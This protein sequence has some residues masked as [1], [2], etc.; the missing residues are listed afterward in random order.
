MSA[1]LLAGLFITGAAVIAILVDQHDNSC[2]VF[3]VLGLFCAALMLLSYYIEL[4]TIGLAPKLM[5]VKFGYLGRV[6]VNPMLL[7]LV[8]RY[9]GIKIHKVLQGLIY[10]IPLVT[11]VLVFTCDTNQ[12]YYKQVLL[13]PDG[14]LVVQPGIFYLVYMGYTTVLALIYLMLCLSQ[15]VT[16]NRKE[17]RTNTWLILACLI[18]FFMLMIYLAGWTNGFDT[19]SLG[20]MIGSL[21]VAMT[22]FRY[23]LLDKDEMLENMATGLVFLDSDNRLVYANRAAKNML[24]VLAQ[25]SRMNRQDLS[26]LCSD[27][28]AAIQVGTATYQRRMDDWSTGDGQHGKLITFDD[29]TEIRARL[30]RDAMTGLLNHATFYPMLDDAMTSSAESGR[31]ICVSIADIDSFKRINDTYGHA[32]GDIILTSLADLLS[33][34][35]DPYG[36]VFRYGGEEF[37]VIF[38]KDHGQAERIMQQVLDRFSAM[39]FDFMPGERVTFSFGTAQFDGSESSVMLFDRADQI[40]YS[41]KRALHERERA[42]AEA[43]GITIPADVRL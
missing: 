6:L 24:P 31:K 23:A 21:I 34:I 43:L 12:L 19:S 10:V 15:R 33:D 25:Q 13:R 17:K 2:R 7:M 9:Y 38:T 40:M 1:L 5:A 42:E 3:A 11:L 32:N 28:F 22:I 8:T 29:I 20:V 35:C 27:D 26:A 30:N 39:E 4:N 14:M 18:P 16:Q 37:A 36:D 41:R